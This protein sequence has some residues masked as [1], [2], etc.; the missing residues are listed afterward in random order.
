[1]YFF[2]YFV[3]LILF[4]SLNYNIV[5]AE[6]HENVIVEDPIVVE[7]DFDL[8]QTYGKEKDYSDVDPIV[9]FNREVWDFNLGLDKAFFRPVTRGYVNVVPDPFRRGLGNAMENFFKTPQYF[10]N[11]TLQGKIDGAFSIDDKESLPIIF[12]LIQNEGL[13]LGTSCGVN[14]AGA[15]RLGKE[16]GP[17]LFCIAN[18]TVCIFCLS[19]AMSVIPVGFTYATYGGLTITAVT[20]FGILKYKQIPNIYGIIGIGLIVIGVVLVN[21]LGKTNS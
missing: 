9:N 1:M 10:V 19:K 18:M 3:T 16:L 14:I 4:L 11:N 7:S 13:S 20:I 21:Y 12:D 17:T 6:H 8:N 5:V 2:K 15:I